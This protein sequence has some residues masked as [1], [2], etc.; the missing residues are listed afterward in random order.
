M[1][2]NKQPN[3][4]PM[5]QDR[6]GRSSAGAK[7]P[8]NPTWCPGCGNYGIWGAIKLGLIGTGYPKEKLVLVYD[9]GC[10]GNMADFNEFYGFHSL[11]GRALPAAAGIKL[12]N[13][14]LKVLVVIGDGGCYGEGGTHFIN[15]MRGNHDITVMVHNNHR[16]SLTTGQMSPTTDKGVKTKSTPEG[17]I[18]EPFNPAAIALSNHASFIAREFAGDIPK[19]GA[20]ITE[21][22]NHEG[23]SLIDVLQPCP[24]F[25]PDQGY[26][27]YREMMIPLENE[28]HLPTDRESGWKQ[29]M[30]KDKLPVGLFWKEQKLPYHKQV[31]ELKDSTLASRRIDKID[32]ANLISEYR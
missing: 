13:H 6:Y 21:A 18:E 16:Y 3:Q 28:G 11:H 14:D 22:I 19:L 32:V 30:R 1:D 2:Q 9:V 26:E 5:S 25:N 27:W 17:T 23:F 10:S 4:E 12:A 20:R 7:Y 15:L 24:V 8:K 29:A 31:S